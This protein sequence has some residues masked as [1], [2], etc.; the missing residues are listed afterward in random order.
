MDIEVVL[1][2]I[3]L[4]EIEVGLEKDSIQVALGEMIEVTV[5]QDQIQE[6]VPIEIELDP[7]SV[8]SMITL[9]KTVL[10]YQV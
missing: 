10:I 2:I 7:S 6:Q 9:L 3:I 1:G 8:G 5:D 4:E